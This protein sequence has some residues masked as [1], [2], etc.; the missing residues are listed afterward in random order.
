[1]TGFSVGVAGAV[2]AAVC[3]AP[4]CRLASARASGVDPAIASAP[5]GVDISRAVAEAAA[6]GLVIGT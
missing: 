1:M 6:V 3:V 2:F 4:G 5:L